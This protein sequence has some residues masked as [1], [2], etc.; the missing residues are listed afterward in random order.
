LV[1]CPFIAAFALEQLDELLQATHG[2][3]TSFIYT[4]LRKLAPSADVNLEYDEAER[5]AWLD[6]V[7]AFAE[8]VPHAQNAQGPH[9]LPPPRSRP[10]KGRL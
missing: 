10:Q 1:I 4:Y 3:S 2:S 9:S 8:N 5:E 7:W 6:R